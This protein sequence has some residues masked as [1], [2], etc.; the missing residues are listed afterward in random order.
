[1]LT[2]YSYDDIRAHKGSGR[3]LLKDLVDEA[4]D[5]FQDA[6]AYVVL[7]Q[8]FRRTYN[9]SISGLLV[10]ANQDGI[11]CVVV[12]G[13]VK[14]DRIYVPPQR[15]RLGHAKRML[16]FLK[17][18]SILSQFSFTSPVEPEI[19][20]VF[21]AGG[22]T[23]KGSGINED[24][25]VDMLSNPPCVADVIDIGAWFHY[26]TRCLVERTCPTLM[27]TAN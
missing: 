16:S 13:D 5:T 24:G 19:V 12:L 15:R 21:L 3:A 17:A 20:P 7:P 6:V 23:L 4:P 11:Q 18:V 1:M 22:W 27:S 14:V 2:F 9:D 8:E 25:T 26:A 10:D